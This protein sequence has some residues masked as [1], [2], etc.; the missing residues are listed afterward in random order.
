MQRIRKIVI[1][2]LVVTFF[3]NCKKQNN[4]FDDGLSAYKTA[5]KN[6]EEF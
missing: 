3:S 4:N 2:C 6:L 5:E 1:Y